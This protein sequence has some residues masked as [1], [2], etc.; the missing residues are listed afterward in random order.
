MSEEGLTSHRL[1][2]LMR[3][4]I[5]VMMILL[6]LCPFEMEI[7]ISWYSYPEVNLQSLS[8]FSW[9]W[10]YRLIGY[11]PG[12]RSLPF[13]EL[14][15][16]GFF[17]ATAQIFF[18]VAFI[19]FKLGLTN[20]KT[21]MRIGIISLIPNTI[22]LVVNLLAVFVPWT[23]DI[24]APIPLLVV[25]FLGLIILRLTKPKHTKDEWLPE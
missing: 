6:I 15:Q 13:Y 5:I 24:I 16:F 4:S 10:E 11:D 14:A 18:L 25:S 3:V 17:P 20:R 23:T 21:T 12:L 2:N 7:R 22:I 9:F 19:G 8:L 1:R